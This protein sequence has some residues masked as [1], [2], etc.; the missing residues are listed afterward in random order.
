VCPS[1]LGVAH[2]SVTSGRVICSHFLISLGTQSPRLLP[3]GPI[4]S[5]SGRA[6]KADVISQLRRSPQRLQ[7]PT[8]IAQLMKV[9][10]ATP[11]GLRS[12]PGSYT[13]RGEI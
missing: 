3:L 2:S 12:T 1:G 7:A 11:D 5:V 10:E 8:E 4:A 13:V 6:A 9:P